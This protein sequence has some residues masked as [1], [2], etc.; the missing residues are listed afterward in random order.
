MSFSWNDQTISSY[1]TA[2]G[3]RTPAPGGGAQAAFLGAQACAMAEMAAQFTLSNKKYET[4]HKRAEEWISALHLGRDIMME[5]M[6]IDAENFEEAMRIWHLPKDTPDYK[7][8]AQ[9]ACRI[10]MSAPMEMALTM[11]DVIPLLIEITR[12]GNKNLTSDAVIAV[13]CAIISLES[14]IINVDVNLKWIDSIEI[15]DDVAKK[16]EIWNERLKSAREILRYI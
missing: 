8:K 11:S 15:H 5:L 7:E 12:D 3:S 10:A 4:L 9:E 13:K 14:A 2:L 16:K 6:H 1:L